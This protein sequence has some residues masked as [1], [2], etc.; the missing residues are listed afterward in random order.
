MCAHLIL[1]GGNS[2]PEFVAGLHLTVKKKKKSVHSSD[3]PALQQMS[4]VQFGGFK[5][6]S[7]KTKQNSFKKKQKNIYHPFNCGDNITIAARSGH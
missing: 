3:Y 4:T 5:V 2:K 6:K 1:N 7:H